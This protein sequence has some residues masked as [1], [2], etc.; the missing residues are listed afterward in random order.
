MTVLLLRATT[1]TGFR[2]WKGKWKGKG[3]G[4][5]GDW[6]LTGRAP[7]VLP[8]EMPPRYHDDEMPV[9]AVKPPANGEEANLIET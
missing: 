6:N 1:L 8:N 3:V 2:F 4:N 7:S 9:A 5:S